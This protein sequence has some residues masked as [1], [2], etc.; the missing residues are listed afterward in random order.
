MSIGVSIEEERAERVANH[1]SFERKVVAL[2]KI[3][4]ALRKSADDLKE[5][6][7]SP[8][9]TV[10]S[11]EAQ[12]MLDGIMEQLRVMNESVRQLTAQL[13]RG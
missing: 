1:T 5:I 8:H 11:R 4:G 13:V 7:G 3:T 12:I 6:T 2:A 10:G 9:V